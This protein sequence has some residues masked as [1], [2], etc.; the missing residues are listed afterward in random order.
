MAGTIESGHPVLICRNVAASA[1]FYERLGFSV[2]FQDRP[3]DPQYAGVARDG[4][5]LHLQ[6]QDA[7]HW[8]H[9]IDRPTYRFRVRD[10]DE[11][12]AELRDRGALAGQAAGHGPYH[13]PA[14]TPWGTREFHVLDPDGNGL[15]FYRGL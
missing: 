2:T 9:A 12:Y 10:V 1:G 7:R 6:W 3:V 14:E 5:E 4:V 11:L 8:A 13:A 15:Q